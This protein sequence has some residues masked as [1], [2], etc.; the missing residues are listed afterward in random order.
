MIKCCLKLVLKKHKKRY[1][2]LKNKNALLNE[3]Y[4]AFKTKSTEKQE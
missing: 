2:E 1:N 3:N 4:Q